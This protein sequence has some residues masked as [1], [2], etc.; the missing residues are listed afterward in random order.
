VRRVRDLLSAVLL[1][2]C[3]PAPALAT[4][5]ARLDATLTPERLGQGTT[6]GFGF[7]IA[8]PADQVPPP[9]TEVEVRYPGNLGIA[10][11]GIGLADCSPATLATYGPEGCPADSHMGVGSALVEISIGPEIVHETAAVA[12]VRGPEQNGRLALLVYATGKTPINAEI[13]FPG[14]LLP[15]PA[16][17]GGQVHID[18]PLV[19]SLPGAPDVAVVR[20]RATLGPLHLTYYE[21]LDGTTVAY[22]PKGIL[23]PRSCPRGGFP[24]EAA[25]TFQDGSHAHAR[26]VVPCPAHGGPA[27]IRSRG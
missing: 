24:F 15:A 6:V 9:L 8:A 5:S 19:P 22:H 21:R 12:I 11:S 4:Q 17:F 3:L 13:V 16:P 26:T 1:C 20:L 23:L 18:V 2:A 10:L 27:R 7:Q 14:L 25:F